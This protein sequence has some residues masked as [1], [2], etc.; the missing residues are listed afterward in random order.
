MARKIAKD[1]VSS[2]YAS[3]CEVQI[4][5]AIGVEEPVG[6]NVECFGTERQSQEFI[7]AYVKENYDLR[8]RAIIER[9]GLLDF[10]YSK[11][12]AYGHFGKSGLPWEE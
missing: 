2:G 1:I 7:E 9:L 11:V 8:P 4:A 6:V 3:K 12:S 5:Y 10:D